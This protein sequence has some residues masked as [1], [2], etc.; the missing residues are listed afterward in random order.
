MKKE[1]FLLFLLQIDKITP[2]AAPNFDTFSRNIVGS[3]SGAAFSWFA[4]DPLTM[5]LQHDERGN[6]DEFFQRGHRASQAFPLSGLCSPSSFHIAFP[7]TASASVEEVMRSCGGAVQGVRE[8]WTI[9][10]N[11]VESMGDLFLNRQR[12]GFTYFDDGSWSQGP[13]RL[14]LTTPEAFAVDACL[15]HECESTRRVLRVWLEKDHR[16]EGTWRVVEALVSC[17]QKSSRRKDSRAM[18]VINRWLDG[19]F[20]IGSQLRTTS[21]DSKRVIWEATPAQS[22]A[23]WIATRLKWARR[24]ETVGERLKDGSFATTVTELPGNCFVSTGFHE[25]TGLF[26]ILIGSRPNTGIDKGTKQKSILRAY[27][28]RADGSLCLIRCSSLVSSS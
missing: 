15:I 13:E 17:S 28:I 18:A 24:E 11:G 3:W 22:G 2:L 19:T 14:P 6:H 1:L 4:D 26:E 20:E 27:D 25:E 23:P 10:N 12:D 21:T 7:E 16:K 5:S 9:G 8:K